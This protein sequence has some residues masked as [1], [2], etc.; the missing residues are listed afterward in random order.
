MYA[1]Q[2]VPSL[3]MTD[4]EYLRMRLDEGVPATTRLAL[5]APLRRAAG[6]LR[7]LAGRGRAARPVSED[8]PTAADAGVRR[9]LL[10]RRR[11]HGSPPSRRG[12][13]RLP[14]RRGPSS[15]RDPSAPPIRQR[16]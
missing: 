10:L 16:G 8:A 2:N 5:P 3:A 7:R 1:V 15:R 13:G 4:N 11:C 14:V 9:G 6:W 12:G